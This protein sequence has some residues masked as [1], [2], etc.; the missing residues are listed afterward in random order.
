M[1]ATANLGA[2][3]G[4]TDLDQSVDHSDPGAEDP[5]QALRFPMVGTYYRTA[6]DVDLSSM[7]STGAPWRQNRVDLSN[8]FNYGLSEATWKKYAEKQLRIRA[9][10]GEGPQATP[11]SNA[12]PLSAA[13]LVASIHAATA[14][15][16]GTT[17][18][19]APVEVRPRPIPPPV[20]GGT[21]APYTQPAV[22][23][24]MPKFI[25]PAGAPPGQH[26]SRFAPA[27]Q[28]THPGMHM[29]M[30]PNMQMQM[31]PNMQMHPGMQMQMQMM[32]QNMQMQNPNMRNPNFQQQGQGQGQGHGQGHGGYQGQQQ[33]NSRKRPLQ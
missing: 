4:P 32:H 14:A 7:D 18:R 6:F 17:A 8:F 22:P 12:A 27:G 24:A 20:Q 28:P 2:P 19:A 5:L 11:A 16:G 29:Q 26:G 33:G 25:P 23:G 30:N 13:A 31:N 15:P 3:G 21:L 1:K 9:E 10:R